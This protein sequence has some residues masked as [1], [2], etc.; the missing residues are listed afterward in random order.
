MASYPTS[1]LTSLNILA[2][3]LRL[4]NRSWI[5]LMDFSLPLFHSLETH[6]LCET[7]SLQLEPFL[8][9]KDAGFQESFG[10]AELG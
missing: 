6:K 2:L 1:P 4:E 8:E 7:A 5:L 3:L 10:G 9:L